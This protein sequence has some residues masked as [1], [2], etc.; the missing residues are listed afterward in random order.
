MDTVIHLSIAWDKFILIKAQHIWISNIVIRCNTADN[1]HR[2]AAFCTSPVKML[3]LIISASV[4]RI[5]QM[6][7]SHHHPV[8]KR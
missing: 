1:K 3:D 6:D 8:F 5:R 7:G 2:R 4:I